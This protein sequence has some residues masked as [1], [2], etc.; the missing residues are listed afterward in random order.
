[1][2]LRVEAYALLVGAFT[3]FAA[4]AIA[5]YITRNVDWYQNGAVPAFESSAPAANP[6]ES[7][8]D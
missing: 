4:V 6:R 2:L 5:M 1:M 3:S 7:W 8:L